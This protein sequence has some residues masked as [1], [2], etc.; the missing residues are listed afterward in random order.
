M[1]EQVEE[2]IG[3]VVTRRLLVLLA[4]VGS[5]WL[6]RI[7]DTFRADGSSIA[8]T[9]VIPRTTG[10]SLA[11]ILSAPFIHANWSH[12]IA[13]TVPLLVLGGLVLLGGTL[14]FLFVTVFC[15]LSAGA[16]SWLFGETARHI[17]ASGIVF[18][19]AGYL[20]FRPAFDRKLL[21]FVVTIAVV[22]LY[23][24]TL[25]WS[26]VPRSGISWSAHAFGFLG[27][28]LAAR[29]RGGGPG[30]Q[31]WSAKPAPPG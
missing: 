3:T 10:G 17:G 21:F 14:E 9:G 6:V 12:L 15:A 28:A 13:N 26:V 25:L 11:G 16:G 27:G 2:R 20:L 8:G 19:Y 31:R 18:G 7:A 30:P 1:E 22:G 5:M 24:T 29:L 23:G 4:F